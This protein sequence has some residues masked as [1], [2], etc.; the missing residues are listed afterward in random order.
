MFLS[1]DFTFYFVKLS[2]SFHPLMALV[3]HHIASGAHFLLRNRLKNI[4]SDKGQMVPSHANC[5][6]YK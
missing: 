1:S 3:S 2:L 4:K 5:N 6:G